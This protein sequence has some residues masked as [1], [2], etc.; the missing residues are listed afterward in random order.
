V[1]PR[2]TIVPRPLTPRETFRAEFAKLPLPVVAGAG[3][4]LI[5][6]VWT[7]SSKL[8]AVN[9]SSLMFIDTSA[10]AR[11][12]GSISFLSIV[13]IAGTIAGLHR[14]LRTSA[15]GERVARQVT[16]VALAGAY[17]HLVLWF[18][19]FVAAAMTSAITGSL[20]SIMPS[21]FWWG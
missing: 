15:G 19:S 14:A 9:L 6:T 8:L 7:F 5:L 17:L 11:M 16:V 20:A 18:S 21:M 3:A 1:V 10:T 12:L 2:L 13:V 4:V